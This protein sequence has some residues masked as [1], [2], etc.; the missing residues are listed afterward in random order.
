VEEAE[1]EYQRLDFEERHYKNHL[2]A[3]CWTAAFFLPCTDHDPDHHVT[4]R[5]LQA[6]RD[7][8]PVNRTILDKVDK[9]REDYN[10]FHWHLKF[11]EVFDKKDGS[12]VVLI[13]S[14]KPAMGK[15]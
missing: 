13:A 11:P 7:N 15:G 9:A 10:F 12:R 1:E 3:D 4:N 5:T 8:Q 2:L 14:G 6:I